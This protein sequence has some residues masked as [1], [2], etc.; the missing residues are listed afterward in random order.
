[1]TCKISVALCT[2]NP[3]TRHL[4]RALRSVMLQTLDPDAWEL[5]VVDYAS[6]TPIDIPASPLGDESKLRVVF[7]KRLS[8]AAAWRRA[9]DEARGEFVVMMDEYDELARAYLERAVA[10]FA[11][12]PRVGALGGRSQAVSEA[13]PIEWQREFL[14]LL[15][16]RDLGAKED[17]FLPPRDATALKD[18]PACAPVCA[19]MVV[20]RLAAA[21][22]QPHFAGE[23]DRRNESVTA[24]GLSANTRLTL[25][26]LRAGWA[27]AYSPELSLIRRIPPRYCEEHHLARLSEARA[28]EWMLALSEAKMNPYE[29][30]SPLEARARKAHAWFKHRAWRHPANA[31][32]WKSAC[33]HYEG[34]AARSA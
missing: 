13:T 30:L 12:M 26:I 31:I 7:E 15:A 11:R 2:H 9:L 19:G 3:D 4:T 23:S 18:Y 25:N 28:K 34:R 24:S 21:G 6:P 16:V 8:L 17:Y 20:R 32:R 14:P 22:W 33:G 1:M 10:H 5:I 27:V 29:P